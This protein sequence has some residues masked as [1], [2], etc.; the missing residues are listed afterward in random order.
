MS[1][2]EQQIF[3]RGSTTYYFSSKFFPR[4]IRGDVFRLYS[5]VRLADDYVDDQPA[6][7][8]KFQSLHRSWLSAINDPSF[9]TNRRSSDTIDERAIKN[10]VHVVRKYGMQ[11]SWV[12]SFFDSMQAD[13]DNKSYDSINDSLWYAHGSAEVIGFMMA[14][15][16]GLPDKL[17]PAAALQGRAMQ[18]INFIRDIDEDNQLGRCYIPKTELK[19]A[20]LKSLDKQEALSNPEAFQVCIRAQ[21]YRYRQW[22]DEASEVFLCIPRRLRLPLQTA[23]D[24]YDWTAS[25]IYQNPLIVFEKKVKPRR[26][27]VMIHGLRVMVDIF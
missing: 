23:V 20:G 7:P 10:I 24:M 22:Q 3:K 11:K 15:I 13:L 26:R 9:V 19:R 17:L 6:E 21:I 16:M 18:W 5:F 4:S 8:D 12:D 14:R 1:S 27:Q 25:Q 2:L